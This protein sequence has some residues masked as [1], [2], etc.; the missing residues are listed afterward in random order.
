MGWAL[1]W[2]RDAPG[3]HGSFSVDGG[4][5]NSVDFTV[6]ATTA[7]SLTT[8]KETIKGSPGGGIIKDRN[9]RIRICASSLANANIIIKRWVGVELFPTAR[10]FPINYFRSTHSLSLSLS[11]HPLINSHIK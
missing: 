4:G 11:G 9:S 6:F 5:N 1:P 3:R 10:S 2:K 7:Q 8:R